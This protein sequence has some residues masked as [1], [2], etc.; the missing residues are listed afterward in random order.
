M[1]LTKDYE[2][3]IVKIPYYSIGQFKKDCLAYKKAI[4]DGRMICSIESVGKSGMI[5]TIRF[6]SCEKSIFG[7]Y[8]YRYYYNL[9][10]VMGFRKS[11]IKGYFVVGGCGMN[12]IFATNYS[13]IRQLV[14]LKLCTEKEGEILAQK[15]PIVL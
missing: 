3:A 11:K 2:K 15:T 6:S 8:C 1:K 4:K 7:G 10:D 14:K 13:N 12:M 9:F 5:R